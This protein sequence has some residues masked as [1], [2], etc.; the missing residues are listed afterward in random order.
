[1]ER[2]QKTKPKGRNEEILQ[3]DKKDRQ[4]IRQR[5][6]QIKGEAWEWVGENKRE[7]NMQ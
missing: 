5:K 6:N 3:T 4:K 2:K 7:S 1:M